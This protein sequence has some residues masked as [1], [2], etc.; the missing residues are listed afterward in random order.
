MP[1]ALTNDGSTAENQNP[2]RR[3]GT[4]INQMDGVLRKATNV[5]SNVTE[6]E[7][8]TVE[9]V[10]EVT[11]PGKNKPNKHGMEFITKS[12]VAGGLAGCAVS[13]ILIPTYLDTLP[14]AD[15]VLDV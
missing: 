4:L 11:E 13:S 5:A 8:A 14:G 15:F 7:D 2:T 9:A 12:S 1:T 3:E 10:T 6:A